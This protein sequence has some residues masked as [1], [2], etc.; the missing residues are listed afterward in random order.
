MLLINLLGD[1]KK[2]TCS[3]SHKTGQ[4]STTCKHE[5]SGHSISTLSTVPIP[6]APSLVELIFENR[7]N[8]NTGE[9]GHGQYKDVS[10]LYPFADLHKKHLKLTAVLQELVQGVTPLQGLFQWRPKPGI[11]TEQGDSHREWVS[12]R[13]PQWLESAFLRNDIVKDP[14]SGG[15]RVIF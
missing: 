14:S 2:A 6:L 8:F 13:Y 11:K 1:K 3:G 4:V 12:R 15:V 7:R 9:E 5:F 10:C